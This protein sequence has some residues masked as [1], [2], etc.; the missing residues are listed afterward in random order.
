VTGEPKIALE[1]HP[2][3]QASIRRAKGIGGLLAFFVVG[4]VSLR[5]GATFTGSGLRALAAGVVGYAV[6]WFAAVQVWRHLAVAEIRRHQAL[7]MQRRE[8]QRQELETRRAEGERQA[9]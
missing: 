4:F 9:V 7:A 5:A 1:H 3:A 8:R 6:A 2:R